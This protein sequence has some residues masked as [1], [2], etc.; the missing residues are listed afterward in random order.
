MQ[1]VSGASKGVL[2]FLEGVLSDFKHISGR[3]QGYF[4]IVSGIPRRIKGFSEAFQSATG[5]T[6]GLRGIPGGLREVSG[7][8]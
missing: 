4:S 8:F 3:L 1:G 7:E 5:I 2:V 6:D